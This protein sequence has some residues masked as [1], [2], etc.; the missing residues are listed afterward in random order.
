MRKLVFCVAAL[1]ASSVAS[2]QDVR[3]D[4]VLAKYDKIRPNESELAMYRLDWAD[5]LADAQKRAAHEGRPIVLV[6]IHAKYGDIR[7][8]HC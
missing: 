8:G 4:R 3:T 6:I 7:S 2:A 1:I 5:S